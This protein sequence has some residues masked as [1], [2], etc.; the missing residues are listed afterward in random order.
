MSTRPLRL[1]QPTSTPR[2]R[3]SGGK[4]ASSY[5]RTDRSHRTWTASAARIISTNSMGRTWRT[6]CL[7][8]STPQ[9]LY[10]EL[11]RLHSQGG[12]PCQ[13]HTLKH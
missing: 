5:R 12:D 1:A 9:Q 13:G 7:G 8:V 3:A 11:L 4:T 2:C 6:G 10:D